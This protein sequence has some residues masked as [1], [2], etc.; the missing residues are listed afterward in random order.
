M[1]Y[2]KLL[3]A[4]DD[5]V[6]EYQTKFVENIYNIFSRNSE[7]STGSYLLIKDP[8]NIKYFEKLISKYNNPNIHIYYNDNLIKF[9]I[10]SPKELLTKYYRV[11]SAVKYF[12]IDIK[13]YKC[14]D[15]YFLVSLYNSSQYCYYQRYY[16]VDQLNNVKKILNA[17]VK[18]ITK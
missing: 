15:D 10:Y 16:M 3:E 14:D 1:Q 6:K 7:L 11:P 18:L 17:I 12:D 4:K 2:I 8:F 5:L 13:I 9:R